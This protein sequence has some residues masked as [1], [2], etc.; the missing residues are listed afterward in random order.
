M[1]SKT[2]QT[3]GPGQSRG[4]GNGGDVGDFGP[5][6]DFGGD[7]DVFV[8]VD[9]V[10]MLRQSMPELEPELSALATTGLHQGV[11][12]V[13][14]ANR[15]FDIRPQLLDALGTKLELRLGDPAET[16]SKREAAKGLPV[17]RPGRGLTREGELFQVALPSW[18]PIPGP[19][20]EVVAI[21]EAVAEAKDGRC[22]IRAP[23]V[24]ALPESLRE[25]DVGAF[26]CEAGS[27]PADR[28]GGFLLGV[29]EFRCRPVQVDLLAPGAHLAVYGDAG[30][31][32]TTVLAR[33]LG[34]TFSR[35]GPEELTVHLVDPAR[36]LIEFGEA[37]HVAS[38]VT[39]TARAEKLARQLADQLAGRLP[40]E[41]ASVAELRAT[42]WDGP[43]VLLVV[44]DYDMLLGALGSPLA[45]L[46][47]V[48]AQ[49]G[50][51]G[52]HIV[53][54][55]RVAGSQRTS[56]EPFSQRL[57]ELRPTTLVL[58]GSPEEGLV[59]GG[60]KA[61]QMPP[62]RGWLV[63]RAGTAQLVQC[64]LPGLSRPTLIGVAYSFRPVRE[65][66]TA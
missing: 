57:R 36:G 43:S 31:G 7:P 19:D 58:S 17:D 22:A 10:A 24:A 41:G 50:S 29:S 47:E 4:P 6:D 46:A 60:V 9:N 53:C 64:C 63:D 42:R 26:S 38:Y 49:A 48:V 18:S 40:P 62:G 2:R 21:G 54:A 56:F 39:S 33:A 27:A 35:L 37:P 65:A 20:G 14:S 28:A 16:L 45:P 8:V 59:A 30:S 25:P 23:R 5:C 32:R 13:V 11:H 12:V 51:V 3:R 15:W 55:R 61:R 1:A 34:D 66:T 52:L 44:D